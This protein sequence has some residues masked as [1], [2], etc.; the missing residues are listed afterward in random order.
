MRKLKDYI[1]CIKNVLSSDICD[2]IVNDKTTKFQRA[3]LKDNEEAPQIRKC[4]VTTISPKFEDFVFKGVDLI[5]EKYGETHPNFKAGLSC[6]D[7]GYEHLLY[8]GEEKGEYKEHIDASELI[9]R[10][11]SCSFLLNDNYE[12]GEFSF[13]NKTYSVQG[14]KGDAVVFP[15]N[16][17]F[18]HAI[19]PVTKGD[20]H[21]IIT[22]IH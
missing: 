5:L 22:W 6:E 18:P 17:C 11:L 9:P 7:T 3:V 2:K 8:K 1:I 21:A 4:Y 10:V 19:L 15:S 13:F 14:R 16:F 20:R 12:G